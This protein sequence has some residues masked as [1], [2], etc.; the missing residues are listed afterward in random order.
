MADFN[1]EELVTSPGSASGSAEGATGATS[2]TTLGV[3]A[4][5]TAGEHP[6]SQNTGLP[7]GV[8][9]TKYFRMRGVDNGTSNYTTWTATGTPDP[10]GVQATMG[11]TTPTLVG[12]IVAG[13]GIILSAWQS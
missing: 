1:A 12:A 6:A 5:G 10:S 11:N 8:Q 3:A 9:I 7:P 4:G 2:A 13:S